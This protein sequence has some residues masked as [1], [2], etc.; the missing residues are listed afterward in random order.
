MPA[1]DILGL[2][3]YAVILFLL[4]SMSQNN[5][6]RKTGQG[7]DAIMSDDMR[8]VLTDSYPYM[9]RYYLDSGGS[10][11]TR[12]GT[13]FEYGNN[14]PSEIVWPEC[15]IKDGYTHC[16]ECTS[17]KKGNWK[18][19]GY[20]GVKWFGDDKPAHTITCPESADKIYEITD[21]Q[22]NQITKCLSAISA[23]EYK[24]TDAIRKILNGLI[25]TKN[26]A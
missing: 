20:C 17:D 15:W 8:I 24:Q 6:A 3:Y 25:L 21:G 7:H 1:A 9:H 18:T 12:C 5:Q 22:I 10:G 2:G 16:P 11:Q 23:L 13:K 19:C 14:C 26:D 4:R